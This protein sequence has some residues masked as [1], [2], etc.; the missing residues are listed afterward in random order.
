MKRQYTNMYD[1][2]HDIT[3]SEDEIELKEKENDND[4]DNVQQQQMPQIQVIIHQFEHG[5]D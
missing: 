4:D 1:D 5:M 2:H 3:N